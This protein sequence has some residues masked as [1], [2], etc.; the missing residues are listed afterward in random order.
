MTLAQAL[1]GEVVSS[2]R[3]RR[4]QGWLGANFALASALGL[5]IGGVL[6]QQLG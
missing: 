6:S 2:K 3:E 5:V 4:I 1:L